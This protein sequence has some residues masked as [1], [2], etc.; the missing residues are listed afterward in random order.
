MLLDSLPKQCLIGRK[1][2]ELRELS[3]TSELRSVLKQKEYQAFGVVLEFI[4]DSIALARSLPFVYDLIPPESKILQR[5][6][7]KRSVCEKI[8]RAP[9]GNVI[10]F[11][12]CPCE[13]LE[14]G[15]QPQ[16]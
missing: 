6:P 4:Q 12:A 11:L 3:N 7:R 5:K 8:R 9:D 16:E 2:E 1:I 10:A 15:P 13:V 14:N